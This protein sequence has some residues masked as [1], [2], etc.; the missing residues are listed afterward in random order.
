MSRN[1]DSRKDCKWFC[2][3]MQLERV[4]SSNMFVYN[5]NIWCYAM[6][7][8][9]KSVRQLYEKA[10]GVYVNSKFIPR[11]QLDVGSITRISMKHGAARNAVYA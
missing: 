3:T 9:D 10:A 7:N 6:A 5:G 4:G 11:S 2:D 8:K 1:N